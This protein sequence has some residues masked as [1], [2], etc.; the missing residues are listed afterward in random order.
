MNDFQIA[1]PVV[2][3]YVLLLN[4]SDVIER[5]AEI[6]LS[7]LGITITRYSVLVNLYLCTRPPTLTELSQKLFRTKNSLT[8]V[9]DHMVRDGL[10]RRIRDEA[11][12]RIIRIEA[13]EKG[14]QLFETVRGPSRKLVGQIMS[15]YSGEEISCLT[16]LL[17][18]ARTHT[19][20]CLACSNEDNQPAN[21]LTG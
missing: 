14:R 19:F 2:A 21:S 6:N 18:K 20:Q 10:V 4:T 13:T 16:Q 12:R 17:Q 3:A 15:C 1:D 9:I 8:T 5:H 7:R 11:D